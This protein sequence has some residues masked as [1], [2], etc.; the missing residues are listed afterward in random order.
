LLRVTII[1]F[2]TAHLQLKDLLLCSIA[3]LPLT[4]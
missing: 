4:S 1:N 2:M 3:H